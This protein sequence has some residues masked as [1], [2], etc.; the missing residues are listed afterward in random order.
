MGTF[1]GSGYC[2]QTADLTLGLAAHQGDGHDVALLALK[3]IDGAHAEPA[4][5]PLVMQPSKAPC[6]P[7][8]AP[9]G[10]GKAL[11]CPH[12][13]RAPATFDAC[14][15]A[16]GRAHPCGHIALRQARFRACC[17]QFTGQLQLGRLCV[18][19]LANGGLG[20]QLG[21]HVFQV[22]HVD[23]SRCFNVAY[24]APCVLRLKFHWIFPIWHRP[25]PSLLSRG[26][27]VSNG[28]HRIG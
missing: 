7:R 13:W 26:N 8:H 27:T 24:T 4:L 12:G 6:A 21:F 14:H 5:Q 23:S 11:D 9:N 1:L 28:H 20:Q 18:L 3:R 17:Y 25:R 15:H 16:L 22:F 2:P 10:T 19:G